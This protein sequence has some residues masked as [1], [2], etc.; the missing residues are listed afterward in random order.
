MMNTIGHRA[1][2][3]TLE[4]GRVFNPSEALQIGLVDELASADELTSRA[5]ERMKTWCRIPSN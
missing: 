2:E 5:E 4:T 3:R 1:C